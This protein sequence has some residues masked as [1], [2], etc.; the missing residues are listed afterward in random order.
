MPRRSQLTAAGIA[1]IAALASG[2]GAGG[3]EEGGAPQGRQAG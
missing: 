1:S 3:G 2:S